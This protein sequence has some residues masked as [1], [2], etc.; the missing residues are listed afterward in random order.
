VLEE[1]SLQIP[2]KDI[3]PEDSN[4]NVC[5]KVGKPSTFYMACPRKPNLYTK[6]YNVGQGISH[7]TAFL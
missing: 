2:S 3:H 6:F 7:F 4:C 5:Q 1:K